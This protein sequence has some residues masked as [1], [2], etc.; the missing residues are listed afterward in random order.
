MPAPIV[1]LADLSHAGRVDQIVEMLRNVSL[2]RTP[3]DVLRA[4]ASKYWPLRPIEFILSLST[5]DL[6]PPNYRITRQ[7]HV[8]QIL[9]GHAVYNPIESYKN[10]DAIPVHSGGFIWS[11]IADG[12]PKLI[13]DLNVPDDPV[14][15][16]ILAGL[17]SAMVVPLFHEGEPLYW[18][19][20]L[21]T[22]PDAFS[23]DEFE[24]A[25]IVG[26]LLGGTNTRLLL[27]EE[28]TTLNTRL[29]AQ[30]E[31]VA[32]VQRA[33]LPRQIPEIPGLEIATSYLT[34]DEAGGDYYDFFPLPD[35]KLGFLIAD[36]SGH[37]AA[38][39]TVM[40]MLHAIL[41]AY[42]AT[43]Q[44]P[45][46]AGPDH[47]MCYA[48]ARLLEAGLESSFVTAFFATYDPN[49][50][51]LR[52]AR[53][54]HNPPILRRARPDGAAPTSKVLDDDGAPPLGLFEDFAVACE[55]VRLA[56]GDTVVLYTDGITE[57]FN[58]QRE[59]FGPGRLI[60]AIGH[61]PCSP[62]AVVE[63]VHR[64]LFEHTGGA[65]TRADDQTLVVI[66]RSEKS[67]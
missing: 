10:R 57:A 38:A 8:G 18:T 1:K 52:Y 21:R 39:A 46:V 62:D 37:G 2:A 31:E 66:R 12:K 16:E 50:S 5:R 56:P 48:N 47:A 36:V 29:R 34:S 22:E 60:E 40:A 20:Q 54:G 13:R 30:F 64:A 11:L 59:M 63:S 25:L 42:L 67:A 19:V 4:F 15:S 44:A 28:I 33:L 51:T 7:V 23:L 6:E 49:T 35:G 32:R 45:H 9:R 65:R 3:V 43:P 53:A 61:C 27:T 58:A 24:Q 41:H 14:A 17:R 26:N 55:E